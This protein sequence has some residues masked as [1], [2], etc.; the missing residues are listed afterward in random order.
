M[1]KILL[2]TGPAGAGKSTTSRAFLEEA[3]GEWA[4]IN[5]DDIRQLMKAGYSSADGYESEWSVQTKKQ[6]GVSIPLCCDMVR[7]YNEFGINCLVDFNASPTG[8]REWE[9]YLTGLNYVLVVLLPD[10]HT[11]LSRN[12]NRDERSK[13]KDRKIQQNYHK[14]ADWSD[15]E[16]IIIDNSLT[17]LDDTIKDLMQLLD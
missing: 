2:L 17:S 11:V 5:Q 3:Q 9:K 15:H 7:R 4:Y 16:V 12:R 1:S 13:L 6:W 14:L 10:E 8:F